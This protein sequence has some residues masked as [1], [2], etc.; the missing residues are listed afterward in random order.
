MKKFFVIYI[1]GFASPLYLALVALSFG[2]TGCATTGSTIIAPSYQGLAQSVA[3]ITG[4]RVAMAVLAKNPTWKPTV[5][6]VSAALPLAFG[7]GDI[8]TATTDGVLA[9]VETKI[10]YILDPALRLD[11]ADGITDLL[12]ILSQTYG[13]SISKVTDMSIQAVLAAFSKGIVEGIPAS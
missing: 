13:A 2:F 6:A 7:A 9:N 8:S 10:G 4:K 11:I 1:F 12:K 3:E 5:L